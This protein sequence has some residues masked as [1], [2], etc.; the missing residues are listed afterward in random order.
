[1]DKLVKGR[2]HENLEAIQWL[3]RYIELNG[4]PQPDYDAL[5]RR[6]KIVIEFPTVKDKIKTVNKEN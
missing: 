5:S 6:S 2:Y 3:K 1:M 4:G